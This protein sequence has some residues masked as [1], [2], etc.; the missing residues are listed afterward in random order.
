MSEIQAEQGKPLT[1]LVVDGLVDKGL[2]SS[3]SVVLDNLVK[4]RVDAENDRREKALTKVLVEYEKLESDLNKIRP[5]ADRFN[6][7]GDAVGEPTFTKEQIDSRK[8]LKEKLG[9]LE[10]AMAKFVNEGDTQKLFETEK[11]IGGGQ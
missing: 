3:V 10:A 8:K 2:V 4:V 6:N 11:K 1:R 5:Q 7:N 9:N